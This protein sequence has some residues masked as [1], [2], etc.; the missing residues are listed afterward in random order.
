LI[1]NFVDLPDD[2]Y[3]GKYAGDRLVIFLDGSLCVM[4]R[5][6]DWCYSPEK[7]GSWRVIEQEKISWEQAVKLYGVEKLKNGLMEAV[8]KFQNQLNLIENQCHR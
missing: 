4:R 1:D 8:R 2:R 5:A 6:G 7:T 3:T